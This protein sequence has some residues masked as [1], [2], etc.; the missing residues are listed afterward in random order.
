MRLRSV[1]HA[2]VERRT[3]RVGTQIKKLKITFVLLA[4]GDSGGA[5]AHRVDVELDG[6]VA[7]AEVF[8]YG[9]A[10]VEP[11]QAVIKAKPS[12][13]FG[14]LL[15]LPMGGGHRDG[16]RFR[17]VG[18][19]D[20]GKEAQAK[21]DAAKSFFDNTCGHDPSV[22]ATISTGERKVARRTGAL[23]GGS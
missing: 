5:A 7:E 1:L 23:R 19:W 2:G 18:S 13:E 14:I 21:G 9:S 4:E 3:V 8:E 15:S 22:L 16:D 6:S 11:H 12:Q 17:S 20:R 10:A